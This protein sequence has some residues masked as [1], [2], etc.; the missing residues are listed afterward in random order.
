M[1][2]PECRAEYREGFAECSDCRVPL[3]VALPPEPE[4]E[5]PPDE[6]PVPDPGPGPP[7]PDAEMAEVFASADPLQLALA[8]G[9][10]EDARIPFFFA[11]ETLTRA[12]LFDPWSGGWRQIVVAREREAEAR[13]LLEPLENPEAN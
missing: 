4:A 1:Y 13:A 12:G 7:E 11:G 9:A 6:L 10:L 2:C 8:K 3:V 5:P